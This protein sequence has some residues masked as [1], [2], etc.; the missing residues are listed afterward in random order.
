MKELELIKTYEEYNGQIALKQIEKREREKSFKAYI[1]K[2][3]KDFDESQAIITNEIEKMRDQKHDY[4]K[5]NTVIINLADLL[6]ELEKL[7]KIKPKVNLIVIVGMY[8]DDFK[9]YSEENIEE[10]FDQFDRLNCN[11][12]IK[13]DNYRKYFNSNNEFTF[14][15]AYIHLMK[16]DENSKDDCLLRLFK[17]NNLLG[18]SI[19]INYDLDKVLIELPLYYVCQYDIIKQA[20]INCL[21]KQEIK[22]KSKLLEL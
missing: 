3:T 20:I 6:N 13:L 9:N 12:T 1:A 5:N 15:L 14:C 22:D 10:T 2:L 17:E 19:Q 16:R 21:R 11:I 18:K 7:T 4:I 8:I